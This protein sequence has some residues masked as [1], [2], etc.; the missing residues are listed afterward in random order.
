VTLSV[1]DA[2]RERPGV[3]PSILEA[4]TLV[5]AAPA[6][7][8]LLFRTLAALTESAPPHTIAAAL[9]APLATVRM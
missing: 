5:V 3:R 9:L 2:I 4:V 7:Q 1:P 6:L 8:L